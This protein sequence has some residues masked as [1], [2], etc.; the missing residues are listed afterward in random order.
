MATGAASRMATAT[1]TATGAA[2]R[3]AA[4][5]GTAAGA[6]T[7]VLAG[8]LVEPVVFP[9][10]TLLPAAMRAAAALVA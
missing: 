7:T 1:G 10:P 6:A 4:G 2:S 8:R 3:T 5:A 9:R